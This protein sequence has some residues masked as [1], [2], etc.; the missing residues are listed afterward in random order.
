MQLTSETSVIYRRIQKD[1]LTD[2]TVRRL[3]KFHFIGLTKI[4]K[5]GYNTE[6]IIKEINMN[7]NNQLYLLLV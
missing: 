3:I 6:I 7:G 5:I 2:E 1:F 4:L